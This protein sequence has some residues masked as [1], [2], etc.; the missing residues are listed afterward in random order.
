MTYKLTLDDLALGNVTGTFTYA[1]VYHDGTRPRFPYPRLYRHAPRWARRL[2]AQYA[3]WVGQRKY[4]PWITDLR[5][6]PIT[7][8]VG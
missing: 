6:E 7:L 5:D 4:G 1:V 8:R 3:R 2:M